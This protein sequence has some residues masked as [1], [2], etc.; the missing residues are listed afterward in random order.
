MQQ[1]G[2][3]TA[4]RRSRGISSQIVRTGNITNSIVV[5]G[6][7]NRLALNSEGN[8]IIDRLTQSQQPKIRRRPSPVIIGRPSHTIN[9]LDRD[10]ERKTVQ[11]AL[12]PADCVEIYSAEGFGKTTLLRYLA[13]QFQM[14]DG[15]V[16]VDRG[17]PL[18][19]T[20]QELFE[21]FYQSNQIYKPTQVEYRRR[22]EDLQALILLDN[23]GLTRDDTQVLLDTV[24]GCV[25]VLASNE[26]HVWG[27]GNVIHLAGLPPRDAMVLLQQ[28][29]GRQLTRVE[30]SVAKSI[31]STLQGHPL[32]IIQIGALV[33][34][35]GKS[36]QEVARQTAGI[37]PQEQI[38]E[39]VLA[40]L[41]NDEKAVLALLATF[42]NAP[43]PVEHLSE[44]LHNE[45]PAELLRKLL[46][47]GLVK[48]HSPSYSLTGDLASYLSRN[49]DL[50]QWHEIALR[51]FAD[52]TTRFDSTEQVLDSAQAL[53][54]TLENATAMN[55][56][57][58]VIQ[59]GLAIE[60]IFVIGP[61]WGLWEQLLRLIL[62]ASQALGDQVIEAWVLHQ[63]GSRALSL[64]NLPE[65]EELLSHA[66]RIRRAM[67]DHSGAAAT[68]H[69]LR[70]ITGGTPPHHPSGRGGGSLPFRGW[71]IPM[72][73]A[74][75]IV[76]TTVVVSALSN[77]RTISPAD[78][79]A[80]TLPPLAPQTSN[81]SE[82]SGPITPSRGPSHTASPFVTPSRTLSPVVPLTGSPSFTFRQ[83][84]NCRSGPSTA[85]D[86]VTSFSQGETV[87][88]AGQN[89]GEPRWLLVT[90]PNT[91]NRQCWVSDVSGETAGPAEQ[92]PVVQAAQIQPA[93]STF[94]PT[95][96]VTVSSVPVITS[97]DL[98]EDWSTGT[99][100]ILQDIYFYDED[101][102]ADY[103]DFEIVTDVPDAYTTDGP[104]DI[105]G[106]QQKSGAIHTGRWDCGGGSYE[107]TLQATI[108]DSAGNQS[109]TIEYTMTCYVL[110]SPPVITSVSLRED[111]SSP[112]GHLIILQDVYFYDEDG[113]VYGIDY[114]I[115]S[116]PSN[117]TVVDG[118][119]NA[120]SE[121]QKAG[122]VVTGSWQCGGGLYDVTMQVALLDYAG[123]VS[124]TVTYT[125]NCHDYYPPLH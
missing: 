17:K 1:P 6:D 86:T 110:Y 78:F 42:R 49:W 11:A 74:L 109:N 90:I 7:N 95:V 118:A 41:S 99:L 117:G 32:Q 56:W 35:E 89:E 97:V 111:W 44:I 57:R 4:P 61:R 100:A 108:F 114:E 23:F 47:R 98:R 88:I 16:V 116:D 43:V 67:A 69:N 66:L 122:T 107:V 18:D 115:I 103:I 113:D 54:A 72:A 37:N 8:A 120:S 68:Q 39:A 51:H 27:R 22:F 13:S 91:S 59:I 85:Y 65:A 20:L 119:I 96:E 38:L 58:E 75:A 71:I 55:R 40:D 50:A 81:A 70:L 84:A 92:V 73:A 14:P 77:P 25:F 12:E 21:A 104:L 105:S 52:W 102:D 125:M 29:I 48:A 123:N 45:K 15:M 82:P 60:P 80:G 62:G 33:H 106:E 79:S 10:V 3:S 64:G 83:N 9:L 76:V 93:P 46:N 28:Q 5:I 34:D 30:L 2:L 36:L 121:E 63:L 112:S 24:P 124:N 19:D 26:R 31:C 87:D 101:A 53:I 94:T